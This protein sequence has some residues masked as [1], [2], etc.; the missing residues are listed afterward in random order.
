MLIMDVIKSVRV[1]EEG[2]IIKL[3]YRVHP[4]AKLPKGKEGNRLRF[5]TG[6]E[7]TKAML[8]YVE[9]HK[10][11][12]ALQHYA[13]Q[14][15]NIENKAEPLFEDLAYVALQE[16]EVDRNKTDGTKDYLNILSQH[17]LPYFGKEKIT[18]IKARDVRSWMTQMG[19]LGLSQSRYNK[20]HFVINRVFNFAY[21]NEYTTTNV[22][23]KIDR[24][25]KLFSKSSSN[26]DEYFS[27]VEMNKILNA[28]CENCTEKELYKH[29]FMRAFMH[30]A[31]LTG[32]RTGELLALKWEDVD[33]IKNLITYRSSMRKGVEGTT[34]TGSIRSV[35]MV[36]NL[37]EALQRWKGDRISG[38]VFC[39]AYTK[40]PYSNSR[41]IVDTYYKPMLARLEIPFRILYSTRHTFASISLEKGILLATVSQCLGHKSTEVTSRYYIHSGNKNQDL[42]RDQLLVLSA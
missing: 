27:E 28:T 4:N 17:V 30:T 19:A 37:S 38:Y 42:V 18:E 11:E 5:S 23:S 26:N 2:G 6:K 41:S 9:K 22:M 8:K 33:F 34:K 20:F 35:P 21:E 13:S 3:D 31:F 29:E 16:A 12:L 39:Q 24:I 40:K 10:E 25:S 7:A 36:P 15:D 14:F 1:H 32:A